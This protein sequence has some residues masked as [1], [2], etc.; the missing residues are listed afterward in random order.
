MV[1]PLWWVADM[2]SRQIARLSRFRTTLGFESTEFQAENTL[3]YTLSKFDKVLTFPRVGL[4]HFLRD[5]YV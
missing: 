1:V 4:I 2:R 3:R 5:A